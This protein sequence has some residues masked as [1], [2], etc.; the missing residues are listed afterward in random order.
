MPTRSK[1]TIPVSL[2]E[3]D[4]Q[5]LK[6]L[7][8]SRV[9]TAEHIV[10]LFFDGRREAAKK[11]LQRLK[12][13]GLVGARPRRAFEPGVWFIARKGLAQLSKSGAL[14][15]YP[16][17]DLPALERRAR[18]SE[19]TL[20][21]ELE[22]MDVKVAFHAALPKTKNFTL[23][24]F[25]TWPLLYQFEAI[26]TR[27]DGNEVIVKPDGFIRINEH[28]SDVDS[29]EHA[30]F[31]EVDRSTETLDTLVAKAACYHDYYKSG[32][33]AVRHGGER[34]KITDYPFRVLMVF[35]TAERRNNAAERLLQSIQPSFSQVC[36][37]TLAEATADPLGAVWMTPFDY[38]DATKDT[39]FDPSR[40]R[41][42]WGYQ[43]QPAREAYVEQKARKIALLDG[44]S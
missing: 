16:P 28:E 32:G 41:S 7:F 44:N 27:R 20:R 42:Q 9:M 1:R 13:A 19:I 37:A 39:A 34:T 25:S 26:G 8:E 24:E 43:R 38:R 10:A 35:K 21:H 40:E 5:L 3:R 11:R 4:L 22:I 15:D 33:F 17:L 23:A 29:F 31:L 18:V 14:N 12:T 30:F 2:Q 36:L 6:C